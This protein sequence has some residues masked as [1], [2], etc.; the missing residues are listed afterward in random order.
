[1]PRGTLSRLI[2][3][4]ITTSRLEKLKAPAQ[5]ARQVR[6]RC[7][8]MRG[9]G[10]PRRCAGG[11]EQVEIGLEVGEAQQRNAA[12]ARPQHLPGTAQA[13][14]MARDLEAVVVLED[15]FKPLARGL[16]ER[17]LVEQD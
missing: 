12:L 3:S 17:V 14:V 5:P 13:Q 11:V 7:L 8:R 4:R 2:M 1:M 15:D 16:R 10:L 9:D 6:P